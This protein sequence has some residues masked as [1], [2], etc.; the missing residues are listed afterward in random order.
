MP[1]GGFDPGGGARPQPSS[2]QADSHGCT[3]DMACRSA[4]S[5]GIEP[6][7]AGFASAKAPRPPQ[8]EAEYCKKIK[9]ARPSAAELFRAVKRASVAVFEAGLRVVLRGCEIFYKYVIK[10]LVKSI[11]CLNFLREFR[12]L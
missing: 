5:H 2:V 1:S 8:A 6:S 3:A 4:R 10:Q 11:I 7:R 12:I 9:V